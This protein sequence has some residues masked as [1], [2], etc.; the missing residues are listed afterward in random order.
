MNWLAPNGQS[1]VAHYAEILYKAIPSAMGVSVFHLGNNQLHL[2]IY[3]RL[4][5]Q[6]DPKRVVIL[7]DAVL[8]HFMLGALSRDAYIEEFVYNYGA[9]QHGVGEVLGGA[10]GVGAAGPKVLGQVAMPRAVV[11]DKFF[12]VSVAGECAE[13]EM[14][15][16]S[17]VQDDDTLRVLLRD[18]ALVDGLVELVIAEVEDGDARDGW[19]RLVENLGI[20]SDTRLP[21]WSEPV[22]V[23]GGLI[24]LPKIAV[25]TRIMVEPSSMATSKSCDMPIES[26]VSECFCAS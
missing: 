10:A 12:D 1:G 5:S 25:P 15:Q 19:D 11:V 6:H 4:I 21:G 22:H 9:A 23:M 26:S 14:L 8:H 2:P 24:R 18:K 16:D 13:H 17:V 7:H 3:Q 20:V